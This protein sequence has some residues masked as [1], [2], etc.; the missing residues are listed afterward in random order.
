MAGKLVAI[1]NVTGKDAR[2]SSTEYS[3]D[4]CAVPNNAVTHTGG[5]NDNYVRIA[6]CSDK[7]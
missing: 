5:K 2:Y 1:A 6:D 3:Y 4:A 7:G